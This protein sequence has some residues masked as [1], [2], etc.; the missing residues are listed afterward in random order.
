[1]PTEDYLFQ[2]MDFSERKVKFLYKGPVNEK[3]I[4][5]FRKYFDAILNRYP[6]A[7]L[8]LYG[9]FIELAQ[10]ISFYSAER[11]TLFDDT[12]ILGCGTLIISE[13]EDSFE[14]FTGNAITN[15]NISDLAEKCET[16]NSLDREELRK[17]KRKYRRMPRGDYGTANIGLIQVALTASN[18]L[19]AKIEPINKDLSF[20]SISVKIDK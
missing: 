18:P 16:V 2:Y 17:L 6:K 20:F 5:V 10:N 14:F 4:A 11:D 8:K 13:F 19:R 12:N 7:G 9:I 15:V 1:M 3:I